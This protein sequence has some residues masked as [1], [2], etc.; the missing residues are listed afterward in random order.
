MKCK[1]SGRITLINQAQLSHFPR[2]PLLPFTVRSVCPEVIGKQVFWKAVWGFMQI[3]SNLAQKMFGSTSSPDPEFKAS[4]H[5]I[6]IWICRVAVRFLNLIGCCTRPVQTK[7]QIG[8]ALISKA[9]Y[10]SYKWQEWPGPALNLFKPNQL[11]TGLNSINIPRQR[12]SCASSNLVDLGTKMGEKNSLASL[13][14]FLQTVD[15]LSWDP[16]NHPHHVSLHGPASKGPTSFNGNHVLLPAA[17]PNGFA[18][19]IG[20]WL[21]LALILFANLFE[22]HRSCGCFDLWILLFQV[23]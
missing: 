3:L 19:P 6:V 8:G 17:T 9:P 7:Y 13:W 22:A 11:K 5:W 14:L 18:A 23:L 15:Q 4:H 20:H 16:T 12:S 21:S 2:L 10:L 1:R